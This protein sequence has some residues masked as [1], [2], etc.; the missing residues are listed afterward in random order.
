M[1][2]LLRFKVPFE[3]T[4][5]HDDAMQLLKDAL[6]EAVPFGN[7]DYESDG[8]VVLAVDTSYKAVGYYIYQ[9]GESV[10]LKKTL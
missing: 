2:N 5:E 1:N 10:K 8:A 7:I 6:D 3:W 4:K 9:E